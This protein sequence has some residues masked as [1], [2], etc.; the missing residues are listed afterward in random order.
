MGVE[1]G[2]GRRLCAET[3]KS[4]GKAGAGDLGGVGSV[5]ITVGLGHVDGGLSI[6]ICFVK[7]GFEMVEM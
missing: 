5:E 4:A 6:A 7:I 1:S 2:S 3:R